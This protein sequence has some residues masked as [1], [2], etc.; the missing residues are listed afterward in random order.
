MRMGTVA[1]L[2]RVTASRRSDCDI[3]E[4]SGVVLNPR[5]LSNTCRY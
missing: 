4:C 5:L 2:K 1:D 3:A